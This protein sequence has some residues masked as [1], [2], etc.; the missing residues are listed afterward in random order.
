MRLTYEAI[1]NDP[2][3][4][5]LIRTQAHRQRAEAMH[6]LIVL[7]IKDL[8]TDHAARPHLARQG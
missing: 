3:L 4:L 1:L 2:S 5:E 8:F 7:P 6:R